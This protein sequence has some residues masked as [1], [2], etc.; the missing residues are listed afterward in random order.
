MRST[1]YAVSNAQ[2]HIIPNLLAFLAE[3]SQCKLFVTPRP[4]TRASLVR[5]LLY[6]MNTTRDNILV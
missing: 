6:K 2:T 4:F 1:D 5:Y 3:I